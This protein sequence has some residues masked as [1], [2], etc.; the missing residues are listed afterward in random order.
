MGSKTRSPVKN[1]RMATIT[2]DD[3]LKTH[4]SNVLNLRALE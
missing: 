1:R 2:L 3:S 4:L